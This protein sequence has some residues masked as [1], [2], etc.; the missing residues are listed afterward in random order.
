MKNFSEKLL[1]YL[2]QLLWKLQRKQRADERTKRPEPNKTYE[3]FAGQH[4]T[5]KSLLNDM[6][7][8]FKQMKRMQPK[9]RN[10][11]RVIRKFGPFV[12]G[13]GGEAED[14]FHMNELEGFKAYGLPSFLIAYWPI[15]SRPS[16]RDS[17]ETFVCAVKQHA[18]AYVGRRPGCVYYEVC[19]VV[20]PDKKSKKEIGMTK[21]YEQYFYIEVDIKTGAVNAI[22]TPCFKQ[23]VIPVHRQSAKQGRS[24]LIKG[25]RKTSYMVQRWDMPDFIEDGEVHTGEQKKDE[26]EKRFVMAYNTTMRREYGVNIIVKKGG[27]RA[28]FIVPQNRWKY[29]FR[30]RI[31]VMTTGGKKRPI[32]HAVIAHKRHLKNGKTSY[33]KTHYRGSRNFVWNGYEILIVMQGK[34]GRSQADLNMAG[35]SAEDTKGKL[36]SI[37]GETG[38]RVNKT[39]EGDS[40]TA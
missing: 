11:Q 26:L 36:V 18:L 25:G 27:F 4:T 28:T 37:F 1:R 21:P 19:W 9:Q 10:M 2:R 23:K 29:F 22:K 31:D 13:Y 6:D 14:W 32:F 7:T 24:A 35:R 3:G 15:A 30:E 40:A 17:M 38:D 20:M 12:L 39:F 33:V 5:I 34:H 8:T 16:E